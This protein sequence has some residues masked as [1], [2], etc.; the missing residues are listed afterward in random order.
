[1]AEYEDFTRA[2]RDHAGVAAG[3]GAVVAGA[4]VAGIALLAAAAMLAWSILLEEA[5]TRRPEL[6]HP[7]AACLAGVVGFSLAGI[8]LVV[9]AH[10]AAPRPPHDP[11]NLALLAGWLVLSIGAATVAVA[12]ATRAARRATLSAPVLRRSVACVG[13][14]AAGMAVSLAGLA[15]WGPAL[16][17]QSPGL[18]ALADGGVLATP[19]PITWLAE[20]AIMAAA[21]A[22]V[23]IPLRRVPVG[24][25]TD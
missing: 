10:V 18:F 9:I 17:L 8:T 3:F 19:T 20:L 13:V 12:G 6:L 14:G 21:L 7:L 4:A 11:R 15:L 5:R 22:V 25:A 1:M 23:V 16:R 24:R 2:A